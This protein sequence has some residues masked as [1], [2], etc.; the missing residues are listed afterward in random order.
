MR[1][2]VLG[3]GGRGAHA[4]A[5]W[6]LEHP[7]EGRVV[8]VADPDAERRDRVG[9]AHAVPATQR[10]TDWRQAL[11]TPGPWDAVIVATP[12]RDHV[13]PTLRALELGYHV[14]L[15]KPIAPTPEELRRLTAAADGSPG[16]VTVAH[17]LRYTPFF[18]TLRR[19][20]DEG[21]IG[22]LQGISHIENIAYWHFAHSY[23][24]GNW[25][26]ADRSSPMLLAK[27]CHDIDILRWLVG[28]P[29]TAVA[30]FGE[31]RHFRAER[32]PKGS[33]ERCVD[34][35]AVADTCPYNAERL[36]VEQLAGINGPPVT[37]VTNDTSPAGRQRALR[38]TDYGRCVYRMD[39]DVVDHQTTALRF[40]NGV[41]ASLVVSAFTAENTRTLVMMGSHGQISA[42]MRSGRITVT[43]FLEAPPHVD[44][45]RPD[46]T[47]E[48]GAGSP[49]IVDE[50]IEAFTGHGGGDAGLMSDFTG[51]VRGRLAGA[52]VGAAPTSLEESMESHFVAFAAE[53]SRL[54]R[55]LEEV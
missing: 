46:S 17:V 20:L 38:L 16:T 37:V 19:L 48:V 36:Y 39:N 47:L 9:D 3:A 21:R 31:R 43:P 53:R 32:A 15:E 35:C 51:R 54:N 41:T 8:A 4:Y 1:L 10:Y 22:E 52:D 55:T 11:A 44:G 50:V 42:D 45:Q 40:G 34:G 23:V 27:A 18:R 2:L 5:Q 12:D 25:H 13:D 7:D 26:R 24:R 49:G 6:C 29:I 14:L 30:S 28:A 33:T